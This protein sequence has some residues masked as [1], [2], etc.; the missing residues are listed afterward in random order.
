M[1]SVTEGGDGIVGGEVGVAMMVDPL[2]MGLVTL[3]GETTTLSPERLL[4]DVRKI[5]S[6]FS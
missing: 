1:M 3:L 6:K 2:M 5:F 4:S